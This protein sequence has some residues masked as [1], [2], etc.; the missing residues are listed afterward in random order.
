MMEK[1][2][3]LPCVRPR[4]FS[5][6]CFPLFHFSSPALIRFSQTA[7]RSAFSDQWAPLPIRHDQSSKSFHKGLTSANSTGRITKT[8][9]TEAD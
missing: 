5:F 2:K 4:L 3:S 8:R 9:A 1:E 7:N 6:A